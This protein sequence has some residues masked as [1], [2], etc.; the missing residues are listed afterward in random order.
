MRSLVRGTE[1][2]GVEVLVVRK[3]RRRKTS[4]CARETDTQSML[5]SFHGVPCWINIPSLIVAFR[6]RDSRTFNCMAE[7]FQSSTADMWIVESSDAARYSALG[8]KFVGFAR[9]F[10]HALAV[11]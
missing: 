6:A 2:L 8:G 11:C 5:R 3:V 7:S 9:Y 10:K 1:S 4:M